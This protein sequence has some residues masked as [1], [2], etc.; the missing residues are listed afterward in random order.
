[1]LLSGVMTKTASLFGFRAKSEPNTMLSARWENWWSFD[2]YIAGEIAEAMD[3]FIHRGNGHPADMEL[4]EFYAL[5]VAIR[6]PLIRYH[7]DGAMDTYPLTYENAKTA[8][9]RF[10]EH[11]GDWWD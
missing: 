11:F 10:A 5:C 9:H 4:H 3:N 7:W 1:M 6:D 2:H 8:M